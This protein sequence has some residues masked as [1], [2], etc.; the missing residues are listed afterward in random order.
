MDLAPLKS[1]LIWG[2]FLPSY[3]LYNQ[4]DYFLFIVCAVFVLLKKNQNKKPP[5][6]WKYHIP[7]FLPIQQ[8]YSN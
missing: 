4:V 6:S 7:Q 1:I 2:F 5:Q 3:F 8:S